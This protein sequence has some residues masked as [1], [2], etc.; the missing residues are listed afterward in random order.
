MYSTCVSTGNEEGSLS[1]RRATVW[2]TPHLGISD[3]NEV[4]RSGELPAERQTSRRFAQSIL[5]SRTD[6]IKPTVTQ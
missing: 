1:L 2:Q 3:I 6:K 4:A 5:L